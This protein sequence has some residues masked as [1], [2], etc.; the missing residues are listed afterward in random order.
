MSYRGDKQQS[1]PHGKGTLTYENGDVYIG[2]FYKGSRDGHGTYRYKDG[3]TYEGEWSRNVFHGNGKL[4]LTSGKIFEGTFDKGRM[5]GDVHVSFPNGDDYLGEVLGLKFHGRGVFKRLNDNAMYDGEWRAQKHHGKGTVTYYDASGEIIEQYVGDWV[6]GLKCGK[7]VMTCSD[8]KKYDGSWKNDLFHG[9]GELTYPN[10]NIY[11]GT[12]SRGRREGKGVLMYV[13]GRK[14]DG[15]WK[16]NNADGYGSF[17]YICGD[18]YEGEWKRTKKHGKGKL[19]YA[20]G[21][22]YEG[23]WREGEAT[24]KGTFTFAN[25]DTF[26]GIFINGLPDGEGTMTTQDGVQFQGIWKGMTGQGT[27]VFPSHLGKNSL[28][29][30]KW[31]RR[32][33]GVMLYMNEED[34]N[35][36]ADK[37]RKDKRRKGK[38]R[39]NHHDQDNKV[40]ETAD[41]RLTEDCQLNPT[42]LSD[43]KKIGTGGFGEVFS[44]KYEDRPVAWKKL[45]NTVDPEGLKEFYREAS[46]MSQFRHRNVVFFYGYTAPPDMRIVM[47]FANRGSLHHYIHNVRLKMDMTLLFDFAEQVA[48]GMAYLHSKRMIHKDLKPLNVLL[49]EDAP[50][51]IRCLISDFGLS[52][53]AKHS[54]TLVVRKGTMQYTAP[55]C[56]DVD[57]CDEKLDV[58]SFGIMLWEMWTRQPPFAGLSTNQIINQ[59]CD[60]KR[61][62]LPRIPPFHKDLLEPFKNLLEQ[63]WAHDPRSRPSMKE[64]YS[65]IHQLREKLQAKKARQG[66]RTPI[67]RSPAKPAHA[68]KA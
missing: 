61:P 46:L 10:G 43:G 16:D 13:D 68:V 35:Q 66:Q 67:D 5:V 2:Q 12:F 42:L 8:G 56:F 3:R 9:E 65:I 38:G 27:V 52:K 51:Q 20:S 7:G 29:N 11:K 54:Q 62:A 18:V 41:Y 39:E 53:I 28:K 17:V 44:G 33:S 47:E 4:T 30:A 6:D 48:A 19:T 45:L 49:T 57:R 21:D 64:A 50:G 37:E 14:Y 23:D 1:V 59:I 36:R 40:Y 24:G 15:S 60:G 25:F 58:F 55:E 34:A 31:R 63:C 26:T 32:E 22:C